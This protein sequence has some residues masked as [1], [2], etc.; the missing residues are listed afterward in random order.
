MARNIL[1]KILSNI[2]S[3][4]LLLTF[5][6]G[7]CLWHA[8]YLWPDN[9]IELFYISQEEIM[10]LEHDRL[11]VLPIKE[12]KLFFDHPEK[13]VMLIEE[14]AGEYGTQNKKIVFSRAEVS[15]ISE[16]KVKSISDEVYR[17]LIDRLQ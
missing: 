11:K 12:Q 3:Y 5:V 8:N 2:L 14:I 17:K 6:I 9:Q 1:S 10:A 4:K 13:A 16:I 7:I 15:S